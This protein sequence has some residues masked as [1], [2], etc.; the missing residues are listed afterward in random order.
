MEKCEEGGWI[1]AESLDKI[2]NLFIK[3]FGSKETQ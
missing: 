3:T 2:I 1:K